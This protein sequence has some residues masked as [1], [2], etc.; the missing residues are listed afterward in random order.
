MLSTLKWSVAFVNSI[1]LLVLGFRGRFAYTTQ[2]LPK[3]KDDSEDLT[4][5]GVYSAA[6]LCD[7]YGICLVC[8]IPRSVQNKSATEISGFETDRAFL[9]DNS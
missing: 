9:L 1:A 7:A 4:A 6:S 3:W 5:H 8:H 2:T